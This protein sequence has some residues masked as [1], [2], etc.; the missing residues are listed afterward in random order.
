MNEIMNKTLWRS[1]IL[2]PGMAK[3]PM[4]VSLVTAAR[5]QILQAEPQN[6][7]IIFVPPKMEPR[8]LSRMSKTDKETDKNYRKLLYHFSSVIRPLDNS[9]RAQDAL[10]R[11]T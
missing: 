2:L 5:S 10:C 9:L 6:K 11:R 8:M 3:L 1:W 4:E 7:N